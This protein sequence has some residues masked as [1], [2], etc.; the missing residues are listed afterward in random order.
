MLPGFTGLLDPGWVFGAVPLEPAVR[1]AGLWDPPPVG[2][3]RFSR[4]DLT[5]T[6][7]V[8][9]CTDVYVCWTERDSFFGK[10]ENRTPYPCGVCFGWDIP[11]DP[12]DW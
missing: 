9:W 7:I 8:Q 1:L 3:C 6:G 5:C 12:D 11:L 10:E 2:T 4:T